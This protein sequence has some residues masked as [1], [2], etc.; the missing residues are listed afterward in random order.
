MN[1][2]TVTTA[3]PARAPADLSSLDIKRLRG[4]RLDLTAAA[5]SIFDQ[6]EAG[7]R[8]LTAAEVKS[9]DAIEA[10]L[11]RLDR[12]IVAKEQHMNRQRNEPGRGGEASVRA[13]GRGNGG[14]FE[15][16]GAQLVAVA[17]ADVPNAS[18][19]DQRLMW[20]GPSGASE[21]IASDGGFLVQSDFL[22]DLLGSVFSTGEVLS[23]LNVLGL[24]AGS[25][26]IK[27][28][29]I[30]ETSRANGSRFGAIQGY[31]T[32]EAA[33][34]TA[35]QPK[36]RKIGMEL[37]K[38][39]GLCY[40]TDE[41]LQDAVALESWLRDAFKE[42]LQFKIEDAVINGSGAGM[43]LGILNSPATIT[44]NKETSQVAATLVAENILKMWA[45]LPASSRKTAIWLINQDVE[46]QLYQLNIKI[47]NVAG[48][49]NV[50]GIPVQAGPVFLPPG[51]NGN[52][53][54]TLMGRPV[55]P[56]EYCATLGTTGDVILCDLSQYLA[57]DKG[58]LQGQS[59][60]HVRFLFDETAFRFVYRFNG[61]PKL[62]A[63]VTPFK[64]SNTISPFVI[65]QTR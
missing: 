53:Y 20:M 43:P 37:E 50:G 15:S 32:G 48:S 59:S 52:T 25:N 60:I 62:A 22:P 49:E 34:A 11:S 2:N 18:D 47:K 57:I 9:V 3:R 51:T 56:V 35:S 14:P 23:R 7:N 65:L 19:I 41:L 1:L 40:A 13:D 28:N 39:T 5:E 17:R 38:L 58:G 31:W 45:R 4:M 16:L 64:G 12:A 54:G 30:D 33:T 42:E 26:G 61:Q 44:V 36:F 10:D 46:P 8:L 63:P 24:G 21:G 55:V 29:A 6:A 27:L